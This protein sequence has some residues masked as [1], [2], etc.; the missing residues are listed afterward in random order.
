MST[1]SADELRPQALEA[2]LDLS[3]RAPAHAS[4]GNVSAVDREAD[5][6]VTAA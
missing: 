2:N 3:V 4:F 6:V 5:V 1:R